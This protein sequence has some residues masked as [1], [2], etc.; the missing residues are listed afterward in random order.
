[1]RP[2]LVEVIGAYVGEWNLSGYVA[3]GVAPSIDVRPAA[4]DDR[5]RVVRKLR[6]ESALE[7]CATDG[8]NATSEQ[9]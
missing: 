6:K 1:M 4:I 3:G 8:I 5:A 7:R 9:Q 2:K